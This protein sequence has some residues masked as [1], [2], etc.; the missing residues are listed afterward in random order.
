MGVRFRLSNRFSFCENAFSSRCSRPFHCSTIDLVGCS[1]CSS[2]PSPSPSSSVLESVVGID[3]FL[4]V[5]C[6]LA[7]RANLPISFDSQNSK[8]YL[9]TPPILNWEHK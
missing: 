5:L 3:G 8:F 4:Y 1:T 7:N 9:F 2:C 6:F